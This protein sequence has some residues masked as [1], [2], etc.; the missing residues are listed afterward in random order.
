MK[1]GQMSS[2]IRSL[3]KSIQSQ[4]QGHPQ[5]QAQRWNYAGQADGN[6][7]DLEW[8]LRIKRMS[9]IVP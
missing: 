9:N 8:Y 7:I 3:V 5:G 2:D 6:S 4:G 1:M